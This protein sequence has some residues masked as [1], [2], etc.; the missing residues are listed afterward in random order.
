MKTAV[1]Y[2]QAIP[3]AT[4]T[5]FL[6]DTACPAATSESTVLYQH[7]LVCRRLMAPDLRDLLYVPCVSK[8]DSPATASAAKPSPALLLLLRTTVLSVLCPWLTGPLLSGIVTVT[9]QS[10]DS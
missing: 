1:Y 6:T 8:P 4:S 10:L 2:D 3:A 7:R 9:P 5:T